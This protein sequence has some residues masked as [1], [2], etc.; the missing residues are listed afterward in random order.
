MNTTIVAFEF[1]F[2]DKQLKL[3]PR[4]D[5]SLNTIS[6][7]YDLSNDEIVQFKNDKSFSF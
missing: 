3:F 6:V 1:S 5:S 2:A 4:D 7:V